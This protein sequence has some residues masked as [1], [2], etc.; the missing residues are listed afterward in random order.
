MAKLEKC[1][2][3]GQIRVTSHQIPKK[4]KKTKKKRTNMDSVDMTHQQTVKGN[5]LQ[6]QTD[7]G[8]SV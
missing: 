6:K 3:L 4:G 1:G 2:V 8:A 7:F 5:P